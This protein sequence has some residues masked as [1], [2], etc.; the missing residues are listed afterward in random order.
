MVQLQEQ[1]RAATLVAHAETALGKKPGKEPS[2]E[3]IDSEVTVISAVSP[4]LNGAAPVADAFLLCL[5][6]INQFAVSY[7]IATR[8]SVSRVTQ[9]KLP[10]LIPYA[11]RRFDSTSFDEISVL[12]LRAN[13]VLRHKPSP[14]K[15]VDE[16][17]HF[18]SELEVGGPRVTYM[19]LSAEARRFFDRDGDARAAVIIAETACEV[20]LDGLLSAA[21]W[22]KGISP[23]DA[24]AGYFN[25]RDVALGVRLKRSYAPLFGGPHWKLDGNGPVASWYLNVARLRNRCVHAGHSPTRA[26]ALGASRAERDLLEFVMLLLKQKASAFPLTALIFGAAVADGSERHRTI[27]DFVTWQRKLAEA[28]AATPI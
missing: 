4:L 24:A 23:P 7:G 22:E 26:E 28:R 10:M 2:T 9:A 15:N 27:G 16:V 19:Q 1:L 11:T 21:L 13:D 3:G 14:P 5:S 8:Q 12:Q 18:V 25:N 20:L 6:R 17:M